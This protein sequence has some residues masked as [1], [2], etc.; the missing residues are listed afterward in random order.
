MPGLELPRIRLDLDVRIDAVILDDPLRVEPVHARLGNRDITAVEQC[1]IAADAPYTAPGARADERSDAVFAKP[2][3]EQI[4]VGGGEVIDQTHLR[5]DKNL[6]RN[7]HAGARSIGRHAD[8]YAAQPVEHD[9][10]DE[11]TAVPAV[12]HDERAPVEL[13][14]ELAH[15]LLH[16]E[17]LHVRHVDVT[18]PTSGETVDG[19]AV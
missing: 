12:V 14:I 18:D 16:A 6:L 19:L 4:A 15:E 1:P 8:Q 17:R 7:R 13:R 3:R 5:P 10:V 2:V 9:L 11:S